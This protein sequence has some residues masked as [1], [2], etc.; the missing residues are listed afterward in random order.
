[1]V[2]AGEAAVTWEQKASL[3]D[4]VLFAF[5]LFIIPN[6]K[7]LSQNK[8]VFPNHLCNSRGSFSQKGRPDGQDMVPTSAIQL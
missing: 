8:S 7:E 1:M 5:N 4:W 2:Q 6:F 3:R